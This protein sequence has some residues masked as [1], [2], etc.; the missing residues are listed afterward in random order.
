M[1]RTISELESE[2]RQLTAA[3][4]ADLAQRLFASVEDE[5]PAGS[6][7]GVEQGWL[8]EAERRYERYRAGEAQPVAAAEALARVRA[9]LGER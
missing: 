6:E 5:E 1:S 8:A 4:R 9:R 2:A 3:E 7:A